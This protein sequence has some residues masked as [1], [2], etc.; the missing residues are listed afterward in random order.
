MAS[1]SMV[2]VEEYLRMKFDRPDPEYLDGELVERHL[3][4]T[5]HSATQKRLLFA[6][7]VLER[8]G[9]VVSFPEIHLRTS[10]SRYRIADLAIFLDAPTQRIPSSPPFVTI[11]IVSPDDSLREIREKSEEY[12]AWGVRHIW[13]VDPSSHTFSVYDDNGMRDV[14]RLELPELNFELTPEQVF[15]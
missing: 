8:Q 11:E 12:R 14:A 10:L 2:P 7:Q 5:A 9:G 1:K 15:G 4:D 3:G 13:L 6:L